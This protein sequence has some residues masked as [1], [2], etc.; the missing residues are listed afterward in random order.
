MKNSKLFPMEISEETVKYY[1]EHGFEVHFNY[2]M[3]GVKKTVCMV[4]VDEEVYK[5]L[6][7]PIWRENKRK[8][9][10]NEKQ[11]EG[12]Y[13]P[14][15]AISLDELS[16]SVPSSNVDLFDIYEKQQILNKLYDI[17]DTLILEEREIVE[18]FM[19]KVPQRE[20]AKKLGVSQKAVSKR[21]RNIFQK[22][23][24]MLEED[25]WF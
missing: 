6:I 10:D 5:S 20:T 1:R 17:L 15:N 4:P 18:S 14:G 12:I 19:N 9:R 3:G 23:K 2:P 8:Y 24:K 13:T 25:N 11:K 21:Q 7:R 22:I 16:Y